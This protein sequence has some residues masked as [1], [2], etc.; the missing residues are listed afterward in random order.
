MLPKRKDQNRY[1]RVFD[2]IKY[3]LFLIKNDELL[4]KHNKLNIIENIINI[5][6]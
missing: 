5:I 2:E 4:G 3:M 1:R 6:N